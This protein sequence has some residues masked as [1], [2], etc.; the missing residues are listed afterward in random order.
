MYGLVLHD[1]RLKREAHDIAVLC[2]LHTCNYVLA[3]HNGQPCPGGP[4]RPLAWKLSIPG[5]R[6]N[7]AHVTSSE[8]AT[9]LTS[10]C[11]LTLCRMQRLHLRR[12][13]ASPSTLIEGDMDRLMK[14][15]APTRHHLVLQRELA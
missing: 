2:T 6:L 12:I 7:D 11:V 8:F 10:D 3:G 1:V 15:Y 13:M 5:L 14:I 4:A 9:W